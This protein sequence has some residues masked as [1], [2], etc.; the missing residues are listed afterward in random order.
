MIRSGIIWPDVHVPYHDVAAVRLVM[1]V[2]KIFKFDITILLGDFVDNY[3]I[4]RFTKSPTRILNLLHE[5]EIAGVLLHQIATLSKQ[6]IY[7]Q[8]IV[9]DMIHLFTYFGQ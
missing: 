9:I 6:K 3:C 1:K 8:G 5:Y 2:M 7:I 4:S